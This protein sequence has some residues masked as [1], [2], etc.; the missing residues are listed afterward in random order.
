MNRLYRSDTD[1]IIAGVCGGLGEYLHVDPLIFRILFVIL[2][3]VNGIGLA[4]YL[5]LWLIAPVAHTQYQ[6]P[7]EVMRRNVE[8]IGQKARELGQEARNTLRGSG[9]SP[10]DAQGQPNSRMMIGGAIL[11]GVGLLIL[12]NNFGLLWWFNLGKLWPLV[13]IAVGAVI[14]LNYMKGK[15]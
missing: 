14:L 9:N 1:K 6:S 11:A 7:D 8:E 13:L 5:V 2:T 15:R 4:V 10:W 12:L 3:L